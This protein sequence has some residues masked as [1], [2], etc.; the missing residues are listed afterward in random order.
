[1]TLV[2]NSTAGSNSHQ[3][4]RALAGLLDSY[5]TFGSRWTAANGLFVPDSSIPTYLLEKTV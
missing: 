3:L 5:R 2:A 4:L 1:M